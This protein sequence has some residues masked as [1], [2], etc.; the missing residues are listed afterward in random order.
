MCWLYVISPSYSERYLHEWLETVPASKIMG[1]GGDYINVENAYAHLQFGKQVIAN[2]LIDKV[3]DGY[4]SETEAKK[5]A[6][7]ILH[8][9]A[10]RIY[11]LS[12]EF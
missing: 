7:S 12:G 11:N 8:D 5:I 10:V 2:V 4:M 6:Q 9:N 1:F 3:R